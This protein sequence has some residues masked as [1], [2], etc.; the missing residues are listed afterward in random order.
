MPPSL[1]D[2]FWANAEASSASVFA[3]GP[4][5][6]AM[7]RWEQNQSSALLHRTLSRRHTTSPPRCLSVGAGI[8]REAVGVLAP[9]GCATVDLLEPQVHMLAAAVSALATT[10]ASG[11]VFA[12]GLE[13]HH[14]AE[15]VE[16][17]VIW[18]QWCTSYLTDAALIAFFRGAARALRARGGV[19]V[20]KDNVSE[21]AD[22]VYNDEQPGIIR[23]VAYI[24]ALVQMAAD[25]LVLISDE[26]QQ[27]WPAGLFPV[28]LLAF[29]AGSAAQNGRSEL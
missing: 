24:R 20:L 5:A 3:D 1:A 16:Y 15:G 28:R 2:E 4:D 26:D 18:I 17:D 27:P 12:Y 14:F 13:A 23:S 22:G 19:L 8:G 9:G 21:F 7:T 25:D 11:A 10:S 29:S 6:D